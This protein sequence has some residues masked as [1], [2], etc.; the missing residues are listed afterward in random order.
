M[1]ISLKK[2][3]NSQGIILPQKILKSIGVADLE[4]KFEVSVEDNSI[5]LKP[6]KEQS[7]LAKRFEGFDYKAYWEQWEKEHPG[8]SQVLDWGEPVGR[9]LKW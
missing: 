2:W 8:E 5:I 3:G 6:E 7:A 1:E 4:T 9:E